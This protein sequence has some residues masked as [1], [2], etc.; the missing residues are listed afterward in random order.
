MS[1][2]QKIKSGLQKADVALAEGLKKVF[3]AKPLRKSEKSADELIEEGVAYH[4]KILNR[5][6]E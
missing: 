5:R 6:K 2:I 1:K 4:F 3:I